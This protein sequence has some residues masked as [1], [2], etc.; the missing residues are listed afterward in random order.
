MFAW[1]TSLFS[2]KTRPVAAARR[3]PNA[4]ASRNGTPVHTPPLAANRAGP[5]SPPATPA[6][7]SEEPYVETLA[8]EAGALTALTPYQEQC[9]SELVEAV[10]VYVSTHAIDPP[11]MPALA[12][13]MLELLRADEVD[14]IALSRLIEK[15]QATAAKL[16]SIANSA[17]FKGNSEVQGVRDAIVF[18]GTE[19]VTQI[20]IG[21]ASRALF[22]SP[23]DRANKLGAER[24]ARL[25]NHAMTTAFAACHLAT[26]RSRR[27]S[28]AAFLGGLFHDVGKAVALRAIND[29]VRAQKMVQPSEVVI[30]SALQQIHGEPTAALYQSWKL[31]QQLMLMCQTHHRLALDTTPELHFVRLAS[32]LDAL[33]SGA[34]VDKRE[35]L[36]EIGESAAALKLSDAQLRVA[37]TETHEYGQRVLHMFG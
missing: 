5:A 35:A 3:G 30:D 19:Q 32:G 22:E 11:V 13:R 27:H 29:M 26:Q 4:Q 18:L 24:F 6:R 12:S 23:L 34:D 33:R 10:S 7:S 28:E 15:D 31:P 36:Q 8:R 17:L 2:G 20:A 9:T 21:V 16:M 14:V 1:I 37:N 25:F